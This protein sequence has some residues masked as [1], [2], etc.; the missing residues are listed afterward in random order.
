MNY[1]TC[2]LHHGCFSWRRAISKALGDAR[3]AGLAKVVA[4]N[5]RLPGSL[6]RAILPLHVHRRIVH[7]S[8][9]VMARTDADT[10]WKP[11]DHDTGRTL[12]LYWGT[13]VTTIQIE[14]SST[15]IFGPQYFGDLWERVWPN[16][17]RSQQSQKDNAVVVNIRAIVSLHS[18]GR[19]EAPA[20][21]V[22][23][24]LVRSER[25]ADARV[26][27]RDC[28]G[29]EVCGEG[30]DVARRVVGRARHEGRARIRPAG[31]GELGGREGGGSNEA[32]FERT[33]AHASE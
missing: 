31:K 33:H 14:P 3:T 22:D 10:G 9:A 24:Q 17:P 30:A 2:R 7:P 28:M 15:P 23:E 1:T 29:L 12:N 32:S 20:V 25:H 26:A 27:R 6:A 11:E 16:Y 21:R 4:V 18:D 19:V 5:C 8:R 13:P